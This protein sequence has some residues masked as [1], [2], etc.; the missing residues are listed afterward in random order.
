M[1][2]AWR[3]H[4]LLCMRPLAGGTKPLA[5]PTPPR[6]SPGSAVLL[7]LPCT[8]QLRT[9]APPAA[10]REELSRLDWVGCDHELRLGEAVHGAKDSSLLAVPDLQR[11]TCQR[12][13]RSVRL[14]HLERIHL[15]GEDLVST[16]CWFDWVSIRVISLL[17]CAQRNSPPGDNNTRRAPPP[18]ATCPSTL[19]SPDSIMVKPFVWEFSA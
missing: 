2:R 10:S 9:N 11:L 1:S 8:A 14:S 5:C 7:S 4:C 16:C 19:P 17:L 6:W 3:I 15:A 13:Q 12:Q 18:T